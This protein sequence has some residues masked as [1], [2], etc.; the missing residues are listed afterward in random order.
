MTDGKFT[1]DLEPK[2]DQHGN[3]YYIAKLVGPILIDCSERNGGACFMIFT[4]VEGEETLQISH[5]TKPKPKFSIQKVE[6]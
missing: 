3:K 6:E 5:I 2:I 1:L 4:S